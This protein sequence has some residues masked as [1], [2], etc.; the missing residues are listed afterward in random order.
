MGITILSGHQ[1]V[2]GSMEQNV[3]QREA[4]FYEKLNLK[5]N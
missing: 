3:Q 1:D 2:N 4:I 5:Q